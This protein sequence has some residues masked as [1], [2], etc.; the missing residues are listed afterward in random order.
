MAKR[1]R[2]VVAQMTL[3]RQQAQ[4]LLENKCHISIL[5]QETE[6]CGCTSGTQETTST[7][8][9]RV[10]YTFLAKRQRVVVA[11]VARRILQAQVLL[12]HKCHM[13]LLGQ[14]A[15]GCGCTSGTQVTTSTGTAGT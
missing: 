6:G 1:Q 4:V 14:E 12:E 8:T 13:Y 10:T 2:V 5:G 9:A 15:E 7:G 3:R 11:K